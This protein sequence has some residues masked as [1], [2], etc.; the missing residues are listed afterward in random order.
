MSDAIFNSCPALMV[1]S[2]PLLELWAFISVFP[3]S[4]GEMKTPERVLD[5]L[6]PANPAP[7]AS[8]D[9]TRK[10]IRT[11]LRQGGFQPTGRS[12]PASEYLVKASQ[13]AEDGT[14]GIGSINLAV[15]VCNAVSLHSGIP[16]SV[17]DLDRATPPFQVALA[18]PGMRYVFNASGQE[19]DLKGLL[20][21]FDHEGPCANGVKDAQRTKTDAAT[22]RTLTILWGTRALEGRTERA[23]LWY[24][25]L[26]RS[27]GARVEPVP[28]VA[29][30][31][32]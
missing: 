26:L 23:F 20:C 1:E 32:S 17:V 16:I 24:Q 12:K 3:G 25:E 22:R 29:L 28:C 19:I 18:A 10:A 8:D 5:L 27:A 6:D 4:L 11:L 30:E 21:L 9:G 2:H 15:D 13:V 14:G 31:A 7:L